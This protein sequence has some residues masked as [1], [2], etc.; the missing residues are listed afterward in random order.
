M[1]MQL[2]VLLMKVVL[3]LSWNYEN[4]FVSLIAKDLWKGGKNIEF[5]PL[6][7]SCSQ[8]GYAWGDNIILY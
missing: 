1:W 6:L 2:N 4:C 7:E 5:C 8:D 3:E